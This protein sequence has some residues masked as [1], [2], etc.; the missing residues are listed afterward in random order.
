[1]TGRLPFHAIPVVIDGE[2]RLRI[3]EGRDLEVDMPLRPRQALVLAGQLLNLAL[4]AD[5]SAASADGRMLEP[6]GKQD[7]AQGDIPHG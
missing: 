6:A 1:M 2:I 4:T 5:I 3:Y 7:V